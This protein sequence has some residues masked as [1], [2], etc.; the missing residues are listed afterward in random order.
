MTSELQRLKQE[1]RERGQ[2]R[3]Q[4]EEIIN[5]LREQV[6]SCSYS[7][8]ALYFMLRHGIYI[9]YSETMLKKCP[10]LNLLLSMH[11]CVLIV[12][13]QYVPD[14]KFD[15]LSNFLKVL[16]LLF[17]YICLCLWHSRLDNS[18]VPIQRLHPWKHTDFKD[19]T[20]ALKID[21]NESKTGLTTCLICSPWSIY[22]HKSKSIK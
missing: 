6:G 5:A 2:A 11:A 9:N 19:H 18:C 1:M 13:Q 20:F 12:M 16:S 3:P 4:D 8:T 10:I 15:W 7:H 21:L 17:H 22:V 14:R